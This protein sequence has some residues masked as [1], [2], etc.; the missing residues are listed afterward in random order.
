MWGPRINLLI[1]CSSYRVHPIVLIWPGDVMIHGITSHGSDTD[2]AKSSAPS[3]A[4]M[5]PRIGSSLVQIMVCRLF[6]AKPLSKPM[7]LDP[8]EQ[9]SVKF[10]SKYI[11][12]HSWKCIWKYCLQNSSHLVQ[13]DMSK[14]FQAWRIWSIHSCIPLKQMAFVVEFNFHWNVFVMSHSAMHLH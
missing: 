10:Q 4:Y 7:P 13:G 2:S 14:H 11:F 3:D 1:F 8:Y 12:F 6:G 5:R 9:T